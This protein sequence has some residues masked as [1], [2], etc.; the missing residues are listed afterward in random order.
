MAVKLSRAFQNAVAAPSASERSAGG[1]YKGLIITPASWRTSSPHSMLQQTQGV[2]SLRSVG[3][4]SLGG[5]S[6]G[7]SSHDGRAL[8]ASVPPPPPPPLPCAV[9]CLCP[10]FLS[11]THAHHI[12]ILLLSPHTNTAVHCAMSTACV[13][14]ALTFVLVCHVMRA[15]RQ[16]Q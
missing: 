8:N 6:T 7:G 5:G 9:C 4:I 3:G 12:A 2:G 15:R 11:I 14:Q 13:A 10:L 1:S 16:A